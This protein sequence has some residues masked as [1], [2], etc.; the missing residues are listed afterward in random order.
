[1][2]RQNYANVVDALTM[3]PGLTLGLHGTPGQTVSVFTRGTDSAATLLTI[4]GRRQAP[5]ISGFYDFAN[6][7]LDNV[8]RIEDVR[9]PSSAVQGGNSIGGV[10]N[11]VTQ[12]GRG[13]ESPE[14]S[15]A[16][17]AGSFDTFREIAQSRGAAENFD[18]SVGFSRQDSHFP[19][20]NNA[21]DNTVYRGNYGY[22]V[23]PEIYID[24]QTSYTTSD[25]G[26]PGST[27]FTDPTACLF[28][29]T[30]NIS[31][32]VTAQVTDFYT[33]TLYYNRTQLRQ[34]NSDYFNFS[35]NR[36][37]TDTDSIDWQN[38]FQVA[39]NWKVTAG[40]QGDHQNV[41]DFD[42]IAGVEDITNSLTNVG[43]Y[44]QSQWEALPD[45]RFLNSVRY[46]AYSD[47]KGSLSWRQAVSY[48]T[49]ETATL[50][51]ASVSSSYRPPTVAELYFPPFFGF[52]TSNPN[53]VPE[54]NLGW[55]AGVEQPFWNNRLKASA[56]YFHNK[57][58]DLITSDASTGFVPFNVGNATTEGVE[59]GFDVQ[60]C[61]QLRFNVNY[62]YLNADNDVNHTRLSERPRDTTNFTAIWTP[63]DPLT[64]SL[65]GTWVVDRESAPG[66]DQEDYFVLRAT[67][68]WKINDTASI[69]VRG[70]NI[71][72]ESYAVYAHYPALG[73]AVYGGFKLSF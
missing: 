26:S 59:L 6:L 12:S 18:Y 28:R 58:T 22:T 44:V 51:H 32:R 10:I 9:T 52:A 39:S 35:H 19:R 57:I 5:D 7:T 3:V 64:L 27:V 15:V 13:L 66:V 2:T 60:A 24:V 73:A 37:Q 55:E 38:D 29:E 4:D 61:E 48:R 33:T 71:L 65:G 69:W 67:S 45:L 68:T 43:G 50:L 62:T 34:V 56:T 53:L 42:D 41:N 23:T 17:E 40:I 47:Y 31:P 1:M 21:Y 30:W 72:G 14:G 36:T 46:D 25:A 11:I 63:L 16:F 49:P 70:E 20:P 54:T 8:E